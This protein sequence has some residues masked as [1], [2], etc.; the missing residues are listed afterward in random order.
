VLGLHEPDALPRKLRRKAVAEGVDDEAT[1][2]RVAATRAPGSLH[3]LRHDFATRL[4]ARTGDVALVQA[5]LRH[6][7][8]AST[9]VYARVGAERV[10]AA[11]EG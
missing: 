8:V 7:S 5:A 3:G 1:A 11:I 9:M 10:R 2:L 6:R 4:L